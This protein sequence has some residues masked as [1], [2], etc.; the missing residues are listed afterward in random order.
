[1]MN[2]THTQMPGFLKYSAMTSYRVATMSL[3]VW[4]ALTGLR[5]CGNTDRLY[6]PRE[7]IIAASSA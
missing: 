4:L 5:A 3:A 7:I 6:S 2:S 1:M